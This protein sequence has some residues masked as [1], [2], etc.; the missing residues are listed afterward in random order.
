MEKSGGDGNG[1]RNRTWRRDG[2]ENGD[3]DGRWGW[4]WEVE[5]GGG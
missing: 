2:D 4:R 1:D 3:R 5:K